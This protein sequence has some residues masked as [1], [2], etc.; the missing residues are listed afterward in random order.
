MRANNVFAAVL[1]FPLLVA[2][3]QTP[4]PA[5]PSA[6]S[7]PADVLDAR[8]MLQQVAA[9]AKAIAT[10]PLG[11]GLNPYTGNPA[12]YEE[13]SV[14]LRLEQ[15]R[16]KI[17]EQKAAQMRYLQELSKSYYSGNVEPAT[18]LTPVRAEPMRA[19]PPQQP[20]TVRE[21]ARAPANRPRG[22]DAR[23]TRRP[24]Q[25]P[26]RQVAV[27]PA[28]APAAQPAPAV[29][30]SPE[31][32]GT[33]V[34]NGRRYALFDVQGKTTALGEKTNALGLQVG[35][36]ANDHVDVNGRRQQMRRVEQSVVVH[37]PRKEK[38]SSA[39]AARPALPTPELV[40]P[41]ADMRALNLPRVP[42]TLGPQPY[43]GASDS[44]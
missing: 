12:A 28:Q 20:D 9:E 37:S 14:Q 39:A 30:A 4:T 6:G 5:K 44:K 1:A 42:A 33:A 38:E 8:H 3:Q 2:A 35:E 22:S 19:Q 41:E 16:S 15:Q 11:A 18:P 25:S 31:A 13:Q 21:P 29:T 23:L 24:T 36:V 10:S 26:P 27:A 17:L 34:V 7:K 32:V 43:V 40:V